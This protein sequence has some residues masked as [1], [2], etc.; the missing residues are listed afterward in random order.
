MGRK[1]ADKYRLIMLLSLAPLRSVLAD[2]KYFSGFYN[3]VKTA[4]YQ[5]RKKNT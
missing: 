5:L 1:K 3:K 2:S 4:I